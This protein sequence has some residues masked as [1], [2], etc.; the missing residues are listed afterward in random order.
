VISFSMK[1][2]R[3]SINCLR[4][5]SAQT[6]D[7]M[8]WCTRATPAGGIAR[9]MHANTWVVLDSKVGARGEI[10]GRANASH[11]APCDPAA[12]QRAPYM[13]LRGTRQD[14]AHARPHSSPQRWTGPL[15]RRWTA[16]C[17]RP[18]WRRGT[19]RRRHRRPAQPQPPPPPP[20]APREAAAAAAA[21]AAAEAKK[22]ADGGK[23]KK[24]KTHYNQAPC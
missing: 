8:I 3:R 17:N 12:C 22:R 4:P 19:P 24:D 10:A 16:P 23:K 6:R 20:P 15:N 11:P 1:I 21:A 2:C 5:L 9:S 18:S 13:A 14:P 7:C